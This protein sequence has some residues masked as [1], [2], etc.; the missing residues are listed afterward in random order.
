MKEKA[1]IGI[2]AAMQLELDGFLSA[3]ENHGTV[4]FGRFDYHTGNIGG[5]D[6]AVMLCGIGKVNA[7]VGTTLLIDKLRPDCIINTGVAGGFARKL[8]IGDIVISADVTHHDADVTVFDYLHGQIPNMPPA[9]EADGTLVG[10]AMNALPKNARTAVYKGKILSGDSFIHKNSQ[11]KEIQKKFPEICAVEMEG[12]A[13]AQTCFLFS[14]PFVIIRSISDLVFKKKSD[15][16]YQDN[17]QYA[18]DLSVQLV[19]NLI[20]NM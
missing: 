19:L 5:H 20:K 11:I 18:A 16:H 1:K 9:F 10:L 14:I 17:K 8:K 4:S 12:S 7:A 3:L 2:I 13:I 6:I 15:T